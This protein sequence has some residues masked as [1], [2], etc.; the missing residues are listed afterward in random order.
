MSKLILNPFMVISLTY[1]FSILLYLLPFSNIYPTITFE[2]IGPVVF[3]I[4]LNLL[5]S[6]LW[7]FLGLSK[8]DVDM[9]NYF[10]EKDSFYSFMNKLTIMLYFI[11]LLELSFYGVPL[12]GMVDYTNF[13][14]PILHVVLTSGIILSSIYYSILIKDFESKVHIVIFMLIS[15]MILNRFLILL[16]L[17]SFLFSY[18]II[19]RIRLIRIM[20]LFF[21]LCF[22]FLSFGEFG[23]YRTML[24]Y[25]VSY[26]AAKEYI[27]NAGY[28]SNVF[29][30]TDL[31]ASIFWFWLYVTSP[32]SNLIYNVNIYNEQNLS[33]I[34]SMFFYDI[35]PQT[36][37]K[38]F[39]TN[40]ISVQLIVDNLNVSTAV[41]S[42][43]NALGYLGIFI[44][45]LYYTTI[46]F[47]F[48][49]IFKSLR[50]RVF[51]IFCSILFMYMIFNNV[52]T[53]PIFLFSIFILC[54]SMFKIKGAKIES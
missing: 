11:A 24:I 12:F 6:I 30:D 44:Y 23:L 13:G 49:F 53:M 50:R 51:V 45:T 14:F 52:I 32:M 22:I 42:V 29:K 39:G 25:D 15:V 35:L 48:S 9:N 10:P 8:T 17:M 27:L 31:P 1:I 18:I 21:L 16:I 5:F 20:F 3:F 28:A 2:N 33:N 46:V 40:P 47:I 36:F 34:G 38:R 26:D 41:A 4:F 37:S 7:S 43:Y 19:N 54:M